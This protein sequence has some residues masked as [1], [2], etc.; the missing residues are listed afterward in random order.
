[1]RRRGRDGQASEDSSERTEGLNCDHVWRL[2][3][4]TFALPRRCVMEVSSSSAVPARREMSAGAYRRLVPRT[5]QR[6]LS[7]LTE[8]TNR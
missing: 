6:P 5:R 2:R 1:M 3:G 7:G 8:A 4:K